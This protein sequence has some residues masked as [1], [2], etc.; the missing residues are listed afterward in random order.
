MGLNARD[1]SLNLLAAIP[2][3]RDP[4]RRLRDRKQATG[5]APEER[6][7]LALERLATRIEFIGRDR[8]QGAKVLEIGSG[9]DFCL[10]LLFLQAGARHVVN[11]EIDSYGF[12]DDPEPYQA[13]VRLAGEAGMEMRWPPKGLH[14]LDGGRCVRPDPDLVSLHLGL[15]AAH[16]PEPDA[17]FDVTLSLAMLEHVRPREVPVVARELHR[18]MRPGATG[19]HRVDLTDHY[20]HDSAPFRF[21]RFSEAEYRWMFSNRGSS[22]NRYRLDDLE[23]IFR[24]AGFA[25]VGFEDVRYHEDRAQFERWRREFHPDFRY[26]DAG[27]LRALACMLVLR[28]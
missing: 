17:R 13:L 6:A 28:R 15:S 24:E 22:S 25:E 8:L 1:V 5:L 11:V 20:T 16:I 27:M 9:T 14:L 7:R 3:V 21:L 19:F 18:L 26:R 4:L 10:A 23:R 12:H 2:G